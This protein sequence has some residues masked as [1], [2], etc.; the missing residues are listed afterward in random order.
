[1]TAFITDGMR[2]PLDVKVRA[3]EA[4]VARLEQELHTAHTIL[5]VQ[6]R[7]A[8]LP[9]LDNVGRSIQYAIPPLLSGG[10]RL[11]CELS[12]LHLASTAP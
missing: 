8:G 10:D 7:V 11:R 3:L 4:Q 1:M 5:D 6:G 12:S 9:L 2:N